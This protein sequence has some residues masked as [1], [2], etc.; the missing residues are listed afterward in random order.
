M[1]NIPAT[2]RVVSQLEEKGGQ[3]AADIALGSI[4]EVKIVIR[5]QSRPKLLY[6]LDVFNTSGAYRWYQFLLIERR[7][8]AHQRMLFPA[9]AE[10]SGNSQ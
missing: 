9:P 6:V 4:L 8:G 2:F 1:K 3:Q 5:D 10:I 7:D